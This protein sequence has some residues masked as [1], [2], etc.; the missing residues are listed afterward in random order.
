MMFFEGE[1]VFFLECYGVFVKMFVVNECVVGVVKVFDVW[2]IM[3]EKNV[4]MVV[5]DIVYLVG[6]LILVVGKNFVGFVE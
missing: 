6:I 1:Y 4:G 3:F 2:W 5:R